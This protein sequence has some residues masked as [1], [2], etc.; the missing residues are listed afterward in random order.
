MSLFRVSAQGL[1]PFRRVTGESVPH[2]EATEALMEALWSDLSAVVG[3]R[4]LPVVRG[5]ADG[6]EDAPAI[7]ALDEQGEIVVL[8]AGATVDSAGLAFCL[9]QVGWARGVTVSELASCYWRENDDFWHDWQEFSGTTSPIAPESGSRTPQLMIVATAMTSS[10]EAALGFLTDTGAPVSVLRAAMYTDD[11]GCQLLELGASS[12]G[13]TA[14]PFGVSVPLRRETA[15]ASAIDAPSVESAS[16]GF[17]GSRLAPKPSPRS[18]KPEANHTSTPPLA[19]P[20]RDASDEDQSWPEG[21]NISVGA[22]NHAVADELFSGTSARQQQSR[23]VRPAIRA[24]PTPGRQS[25]SISH[26]RRKQL[27][28][29]DAEMTGETSADPLEAEAASPSPRGDQAA[30]DA[31]QAPPLLAPLKFPSELAEPAI[32]EELSGS[33][34][35]HLAGSAAAN[36][37]GSRGV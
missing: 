36:G 28:V 37:R 17:H 18:S 16:S 6:D 11:Q 3:R 33:Q 22:M 20:S 8:Y 29:G 24:T 10:A 7:V 1:I 35:A 19:S 25:R 13:Q 26:L 30:K 34:T 31:E 14:A 9:E 12:A 5:S 15:A 21:R 32:P 2:V 27:G 4:L 23:F